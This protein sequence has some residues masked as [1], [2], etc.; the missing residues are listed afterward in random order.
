MLIIL[1]FATL[2][3]LKLAAIGLVYYAGTI[4]AILVIAACYALACYIEPTAA[5][6]G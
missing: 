4:A 5:K 1:L 3:A 6:P 2:L